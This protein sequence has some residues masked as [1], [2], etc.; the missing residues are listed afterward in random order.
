[1]L[2][3]GLVVVYTIFH[4]WRVQWGFPLG[5][6]FFFRGHKVQK[7]KAEDLSSCKQ[8]KDLM[9]G[10]VKVVDTFIARSLWMNE[11]INRAE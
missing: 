10:S 4:C 6:L 3:L 11:L 8:N 9:N 1:M 7:K 5:S 2:S